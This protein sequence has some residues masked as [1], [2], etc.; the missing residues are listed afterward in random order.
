MWQRVQ[1]STSLKKKTAMHVH[2]AC[3]HKCSKCDKTFPFED[4]KKFHEKVHDTLP[5]K[6][7]Q[8]GCSS[9][10]SRDS[11]LKLHSM[12]THGS[13]PIKCKHCDYQN[14]VDFVVY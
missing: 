5:F 4:Q 14:T 9:F 13:E 8:D 11:D 12:H 10:F 1:Q 6:C 3:H 2:R 7:T